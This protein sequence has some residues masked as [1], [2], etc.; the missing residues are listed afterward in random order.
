MSRPS[1]ANAKP[2]AVKAANHNDLTPPPTTEET[3][4]TVVLWRKRRFQS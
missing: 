1:A 2:V 4:N 3:E